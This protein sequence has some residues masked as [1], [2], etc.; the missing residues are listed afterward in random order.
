[1]GSTSSMMA[2]TGGILPT[3]HIEVTSTGDS[4][5]ETVSLVL[6]LSATCGP[7]VREWCTQWQLGE[8]AVN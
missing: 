5:A 6:R 4:T 1:M 7:Q 8:V 2:K 3:D